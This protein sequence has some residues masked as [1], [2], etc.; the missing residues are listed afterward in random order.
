MCYNAGMTIAATAQ[1]SYV[2]SPGCRLRCD[3]SAIDAAL[4]ACAGQ[5]IGEGTLNVVARDGSA[6]A[7]LLIPARCDQGFPSRTTV[8]L[9]DEEWILDPVIWDLHFGLPGEA[10]VQAPREERVLITGNTYPIREALKALGGRWD[11]DAQGWRVPA[12]N[13][14]QAKA[15]VADAGPTKPR[16][17]R[18]RWTS[19]RRGN[20]K[21]SRSKRKAPAAREFVIVDSDAKIGECLPSPSDPSVRVKVVGIEKRQV[22]ANAAVGWIETHVRIAKPVRGYR[23]K[24]S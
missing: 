6:I 15:L 21:A 2:S 9:P 12:S 13:A 11:G 3:A 22:Y 19:S 24:A 5:P 23:R 7:L 4:E 17:Q 18:A 14:A 1:A 8:L 20:G 10:V 16:R